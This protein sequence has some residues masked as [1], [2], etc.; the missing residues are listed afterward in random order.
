MNELQLHIENINV[1]EQVR[2][3]A[4]G[5]GAGMLTT[6][7]KHWN[8]YEVY[9]VAD[10][11]RWEAR[12]LYYEL[13]TSRFGFKPHYGFLLKKTTEELNEMIAALPARW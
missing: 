13:Y 10:F 8:I 12:T 5:E 9:T 3:E 11:I 7:L 1:A 2:A 6:D 4:M